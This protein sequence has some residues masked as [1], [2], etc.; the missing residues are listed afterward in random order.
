M[1]IVP[2]PLYVCLSLETAEA[3][4]ELL[5]LCKPAFS[6]GIGLG[7]L[8]KPLPSSEAWGHFSIRAVNF[9]EEFPSSTKS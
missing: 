9:R 1:I 4:P 8:Q 7:D 3:G 5:G 6:R 2:I